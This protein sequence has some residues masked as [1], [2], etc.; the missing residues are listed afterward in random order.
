MAAWRCCF[1]PSGVMES[2]KL[3]GWWAEIMIK[4]DNVLWF[5]SWSLN[6]TFLQQRWLAESAVKNQN[7]IGDGLKKSKMLR[8]IFSSVFSNAPPVVTGLISLFVF[9][10]AV[11]H[12]RSFSS[13][14]RRLLCFTEVCDCSQARWFCWLNALSH[15]DRGRNRR[16]L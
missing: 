15:T 2:G 1:L 3:A 13:Q 7:N 9:I 6:L 11:G 4:T 12:L 14:T 16:F 8:S 10:A 5:G